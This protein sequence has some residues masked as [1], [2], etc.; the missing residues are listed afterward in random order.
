MGNTGQVSEENSSFMLALE[1]STKL[2]RA[3]IFSG[4]NFL[5]ERVCPADLS[6]ARA[7]F[8]LIS[9]LVEDHRQKMSNIGKI[10]VTTGPG[11]FTGLRV[12]VTIAKS[13]AF[14][15]QCSVVGIN[16]LQ[17]MA[18]RFFDGNPAVESVICSI[19]AQRNQL[20][21]AAF[22]QAGVRQ[23]SP[24]E[25]ID[26]DDFVSQFQGQY[27]TGEGLVKLDLPESTPL[28]IADPSWWQATARATGE[29]A[30]Q[31]DDS[32]SFWEIEPNYFRQSAAEE[33]LS[34]KK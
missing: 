17:V 11:S 23:I 21:V 8:P 19:D 3:A 6:T 16:T 22:S 12:G 28:H 34:K 32:D 30:L 25:I 10:A 5:E 4:E 24:V 13:I 14:A 15:N 2:G 9:E 20:F 18:S 26:R 27:V 33:K 7:I 1:C 29:L 31:R